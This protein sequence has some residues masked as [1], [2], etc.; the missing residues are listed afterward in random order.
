MVRVDLYSIETITSKMGWRGAIRTDGTR[1]PAVGI[2]VRFTRLIEDATII[3]S[4]VAGAGKLWD[5]SQ[6]EYREVTND[7][8][9][10]EA[11]IIIGK[12]RRSILSV[13]GA[14]TW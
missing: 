2:P 11:E 13:Y 7:D 1:L 14:N 4:G 10:P 3:R 12:T 6:L 5:S 9:V 8:V